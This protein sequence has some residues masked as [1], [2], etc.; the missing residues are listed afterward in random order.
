WQKENR[1]VVNAAVMGVITKKNP[2][3]EPVTNASPLGVKLAALSETVKSA[4]PINSALEYCGRMRAAFSSRQQKE[5]RI[6][7]YQVGSEALGEIIAIGTL[8]Q[9]QVESLR[10]TLQ[11]RAN[12]WRKR[13][14]NSAY[15]TSGLALV[16]SNLDSR[17]TLA[18]YVGSNGV[19]APAQHVSNA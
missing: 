14:Y 6:G 3:A 10:A 2:N 4:A 9:T 17:G 15:S 8:V 11:G 5:Q 12:H 7:E 18:L 16:G 19:S 1:D 13:I